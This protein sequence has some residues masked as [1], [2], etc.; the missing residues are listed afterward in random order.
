MIVMSETS[1]ADCA[2]EKTDSAL[3]TMKAQCVAHASFD[4]VLIRFLSVKSVV[5]VFSVAQGR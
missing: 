1:T 2:D 3:V 4:L 5:D